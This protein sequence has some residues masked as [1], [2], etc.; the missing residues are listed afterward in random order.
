MNGRVTVIGAGLVGLAT[1][2][3][4]ASGGVKVVVLEAEDD[5]CRHQSGHNSGVI[6]SGLYYAPG[7]NK[8]RLCTS[9]RERLY[10]LCAEEDIAHRRCGKLVVATSEAETSRLTE[11]ERRGRENGLFGL[12]RLRAE[13]ISTRFP[14]ITGVAALWV[15]Q[16]GIVDFGAVGRVLARRLVEHG[17]E[18]RT[19]HRVV[20]IRESGGSIRVWA[21]GEWLEADVLVNCAGLHSDRVAGLAGIQPDVRIVP[22]RGEYRT[23]GEEASRRIEVPIYP[24]P[25]P[26]FPFLGVHVTPAVTGRAEAGPNAVLALHRHGY[27]WARIS[28]R[29]MWATFSWPG[30]WRLA[31]RHW[32]FGV[33]EFVRSLNPRAFGAAVQKL[34]PG[35]SAADFEGGGAGVRAQALDRNGRL[36]D[37][38]CFYEA[39][40]QVHVLNA[41]SPAATACLAIGEEIAGRARGLF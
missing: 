38:F 33:Q 32:R 35:L 23:L 5:I 37:D 21:A 39:G 22:F 29:D 8:A 26:D 34:V 24:V 18:I 12:T 14:E 28:L 31:A 41:P 7:S 25:D 2:L 17:G 40:R 9:G 15:P 1:A 13:E 20:K 3:E 10:R 16:T 11:L 27:S 19:G 4:M 6:H 30:F 36:L